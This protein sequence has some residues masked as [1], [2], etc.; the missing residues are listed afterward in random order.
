VKLLESESVEKANEWSQ[1]GRRWCF[2][3]KAHIHVSHFERKVS[4]DKVGLK[5]HCKRCEARLK[6]Q[7]D[8]LGELVS[9]HTGLKGI[10]DSNAIDVV[11]PFQIHNSWE[12]TS[13]DDN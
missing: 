11:S 2:G 9:K 1:D 13:W 5:T 8:E 4:K 7:P 12:K 10:G 3:C 6:E